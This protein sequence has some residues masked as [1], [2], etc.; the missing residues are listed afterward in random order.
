MLALCATLWAMSQRVQSHARIEK[1]R[2]EIA[3]LRAS[4]E[5]AQASVEA[6]DRPCWPWRMAMPSWPRGREPCP[7]RDRPGRALP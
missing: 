3:A 6:F 4:A 1:L 5:T 2:S 7:V